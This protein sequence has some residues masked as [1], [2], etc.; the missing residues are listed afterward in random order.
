M[1][2]LSQ[3]NKRH[4]LRYKLY[5]PDDTVAERSRLI[6][7][8]ADARQKLAIANELEAF[9]ASQTYTVHQLRTWSNLAIIS[10]FIQDYLFPLRIF[11][12]KKQCC[13]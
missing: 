12:V 3:V 9:T 10:P 4:C 6:N 8:I 13:T 11:S 7:S 1:A 5:L 2:T